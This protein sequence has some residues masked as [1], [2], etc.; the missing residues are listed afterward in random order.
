MGHMCYDSYIIWVSFGYIA[1]IV[2][3][4]QH[5]HSKHTHTQQGQ[6]DQHDS[7]LLLRWTV[8]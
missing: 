4:S 5:A 7:V 8:H 2:P 6:G 3:P 1:Y